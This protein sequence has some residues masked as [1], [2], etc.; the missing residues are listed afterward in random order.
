[1]LANNA[2]SKFFVGG[3]ADCGTVPR[4]RNGRFQVRLQVF[5]IRTVP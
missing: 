3:E 4:P 5:I 1:M 2:A